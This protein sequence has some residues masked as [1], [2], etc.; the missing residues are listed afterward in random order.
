VDRPNSN[1]EALDTLGGTSPTNNGNDACE[2]MFSKHKYRTKIGGH[3]GLTDRCAQ[4][5]NAIDARV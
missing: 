2:T 4:Q 3:V 1:L 5:S